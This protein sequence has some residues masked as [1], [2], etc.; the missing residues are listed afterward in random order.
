[1]PRVIVDDCSMAPLLV[2]FGDVDCWLLVGAG[3]YVADC[4]ACAHIYA[5]HYSY[6]SC[7][8]SPGVTLR[9]VYWLT[10]YGDLRYGCC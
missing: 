8:D 7:G 9:G 10:I 3:R 6:S 2:N 1:M 5:P 4:P